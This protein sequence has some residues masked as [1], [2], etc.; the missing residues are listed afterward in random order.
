MVRIYLLSYTQCHEAKGDSCLLYND[1][2]LSV[3]GF[4]TF[5]LVVEHAVGFCSVIGKTEP[6]MLV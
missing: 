1:T 2:D 3:I 5:Y 4:A 6:V